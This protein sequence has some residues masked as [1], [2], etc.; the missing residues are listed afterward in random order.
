M[1]HQIF[2]KIPSLQI[3]ICQYCQHG[4]HPKEVATH[5][6]TKHSMKPRESKPIANRVAQWQ[7]IIQQ[8]EAVHIP[9]ELD[10][11]IPIIPVY[12]NRLQCQRDPSQCTAITTSI[13]AMRNHWQ[14]KYGWSQHYQR[15]AVPVMKQAQQEAEL[16]QSS[17]PVTW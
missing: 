2:E 10:N 17:R 9:R 15:G 3:I 11:P 1:E 14:E 6:Q 12:T 7:D 16:Q 8:P 13:K 4:V 5:L